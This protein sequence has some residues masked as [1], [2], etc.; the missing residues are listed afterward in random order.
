[1][2]GLFKILQI[3]EVQQ[4][5]ISKFNISINESGISWILKLSDKINDVLSKKNDYLGIEHFDNL[6][7]IQ[8]KLLVFILEDS[9]Y[10][11]SFPNQASIRPN[12]ERQLRDVYYAKEALELI[13][14]D[15]DI[16]YISGIAHKLHTS[17]Y[18]FERERKIAV[19]EIL[20]LYSKNLL[21]LPVDD[22]IRCLNVFE[23]IIPETLS[24]SVIIRLGKEQKVLDHLLHY[25]T[26]DNSIQGK[27]ED[28]LRVLAAY[29]LL[30]KPNQNTMELVIYRATFYRYLYILSGYKHDILRNK[31]FELLTCLNTSNRN[32]YNWQDLINFSLP[33]FIK[34]VISSLSTFPQGDS[35][36]WI[37][38]GHGEIEINNSQITFFP[39]YVPKASLY[40]ALDFFS[41]R[42]VVTSSLN[43]IHINDTIDAL[44]SLW[45]SI[46]DEY[47]DRPKNSVILEKE[48]PEVGAIVKIQI[49]NLHPT[50]P[51]FA[52]VRILD[53]RYAGDGVLHVKE[54]TRVRIQ[55]LEGII[56]QGDVM[57]AKVIES[58]PERLSFSIINELDLFVGAR[59]HSGETTHAKLLSKREDLLTWMSEDGY[60]LYNGPSSNF[61]PEIGDCFVLKL[62]EV[63]CNGYIKAKMIEPAGDIE[64]ENHEAVANLVYNY[65]D[66]NEQTYNDIEEDEKAG[67][68]L[69]EKVISELEYF[70][71][72]SATSEQDIFQKI[73]FL[74][75]NVLVN[76]ISD[77]REAQQYHTILIDYYLSLY[78]FAKGENLSNRICIT[79]DM[80]EQYP[81]LREKKNTLLILSYNSEEYNT[82]LLSFTH[83][84]TP[85]NSQLAKFMLFNNLSRAIKPELTSQIK[86][87]IFSLLS[88]KLEEPTKEKGPQKS[89]KIVDFGIENNYR[90]FKT[91]IVFSNKNGV[92]NLD[93]Q[94]EVILRTIC[95]FLN[96]QGGTLYIGINDD[97]I[98]IG[99]EED[100]QFM[101]CNEDTYQLNIRQ[102]VVENLGKDINSLLTFSFRKYGNKTVCAIAV[103]SYHTVVKLHNTVFQRQGNA[104]RPLESKNVKL[105]MQRKKGN[106]LTNKAPYPL[107]PEDSDYHSNQ[108]RKTELDTNDKIA[109]SVFH[110]YMLNKGYFSILKN[111][112][113]ILTESSPEFATR[114]TLPLP[115]DFSYSYLLFLYANGYA[116]LVPGSIL[117]NKKLDFE[118]ENALNQDSEI[119]FITFVRKEDFLLIFSELKKEEYTKVMPISKIKE[120]TGVS[121]KGSQILPPF[122]RI[123][124]VEIL[125]LDQVLSLQIDDN[126]NSLGSPRTSLDT[127]QDQLYLKKLVGL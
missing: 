99:I 111:N 127:L 13:E 71:D 114:L 40:K 47:T 22:Y 85:E 14:T 20:Y 34:K 96:A 57:S 79:E 123:I 41:T 120:G 89:I 88:L 43:N 31:V 108:D 39:N 84:G 105:L 51:L 107:F 86:T 42:L 11:D 78:K 55:T 112:K 49:K 124:L 92:A 6:I 26:R 77:N 56:N 54:I 95:G 33:A 97:G 66:E 28:S 59:F 68:D 52:F 16:A 64:I 35:R 122:D 19:L 25:N 24:R 74:Y 63:G 110:R 106:G 32:E 38:K 76:T 48:R 15:K 44:V 29:I 83:G 103:P 21:S 87:D 80:I 37:F 7:D 67:Y 9:N 81:A 53:D 3:S 125:T 126:K 93:N 12:L 72:M 75:L 102:Y 1:M 113:Y 69:P 118:Y 18:I 73:N 30:Y 36:R 119:V 62:T 46:T 60:T 82:E 10:L 109:S 115:E 121:L 117:E 116:N 104:T 50:N 58:T 27:G 5:E 17:G 8:Y 23:N 4:Q 91:S 94:L 2:E 100:L 98:P 90:E 101:H 70:L 61:E 45:R 65:K